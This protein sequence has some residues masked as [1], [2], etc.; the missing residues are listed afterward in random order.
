MNNFRKFLIP[1]AIVVVFLVAMTGGAIADRLF[2]IRPLDQFFPPNPSGE[3]TS[4]TERKIVREESAVIDIAERV[5][6]NVVT[7]S[8]EE[9][10]R[11][12]LEF[13]PFG[14]LSLREQGG[15]QDLATGF[16]VGSDGLIVTNKHVVGNTALKYKVIT[17]DSKEYA[18]KNIYRDPSNDLAL[19]KIDAPAGGLSTIELGDSDNLK[20]GQFVVAI[21]TALGEFRHTVTTGVISGLGRGITAGSG[22]PFE[23]YAERLDNVIQTDAAINPGNSG[24]P[25]LDSSGSVIGVNVAVAQGAQNIGFALPVNILKSSIDQ[26]RQTGEFVRPF[27]GVQYQMISREAA[28]TNEIPEG[29]YVGDIVKGSAAANAGVKVGDV[30]LKL[31]GEKVTDSNGGLAALVNKHK[32]GDKIQIEVWRDG[33]TL[34]LTTTLTQSQE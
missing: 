5:S 16:I 25:L 1:V 18:V 24:G 33:E 34:T 8:V 4:I 9:P 32:V 27:L 2:G 21:G 14:G 12:S 13:D 30:I 26:F 6:P 3:A 15:E 19:L 29:A 23:G 31:G 17:K 28:I 10:K 20:V 7:I 11:R 22:N